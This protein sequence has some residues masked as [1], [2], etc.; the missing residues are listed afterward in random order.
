VHGIDI[1]APMVA[2]LREKPGGEDLPVTI[3][4]FATTRAEGSFRL[5][6]LAWNAIT[7][8]TTQDEQVACFRNA[9]AHLQVGGCLLVE[10]DLPD[11]RRL[12]PGETVHA[13]EVRPTRLLFDEYDTSS[14][15]VVSHHLWKDGETFASSSA[16][17]RYVWPSELDLMARLAGLR[18][19]LRWGGWRRE[20][21]TS[22]STL[23]VSVWEEVS[24]PEGPLRS[25]E[26]GSTPVERG[27]RRARAARR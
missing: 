23:C 4:D 1:S 19:R 3:G 5:V 13:S 17:Y 26:R 27:L 16:P 21:F 25:L 8:L 12:P 20:P 10:V 18:L 22:D 7:N 11:L 24:A 15:T 6:F 9:A 2:R 14:Q